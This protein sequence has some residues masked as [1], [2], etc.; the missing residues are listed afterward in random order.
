MRKMSRVQAEKKVK[1]TRMCALV[2]GYYDGKNC[3][4]VNPGTIIPLGYINPAGHRMPRASYKMGR[5]LAHARRQG[6]K[7]N[8]PIKGGLHIR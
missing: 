5:G 3:R 8:W 2:G 1:E 7:E 6:N 4:S